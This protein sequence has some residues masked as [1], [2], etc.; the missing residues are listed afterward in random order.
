M[1]HSLGFSVLDIVAL[2]YFIIVWGGY[3]KF[4]EMNRNKQKCL[5][6][7]METYRH[8]WF[9]TL[10]K[11]EHRVI[12]TGVMSGLQNGTAFFASSALFAIGGSISLLA[13]PETLL[14]VSSN[15]PGADNS[16]PLFLIEFKIIG[17]ALIFVYAFFKLAWAYRLFNYSAIMIGAAPIRDERDTPEAKD[18][19]D[20]GAKLNII[21]SKHF[22]RGIRAF[23]FALGYLGWFIHPLLWM[24]STTFVAI[25]IYRR[26]FNSDALRALQ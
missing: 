19:T 7:L 15:I 21:A 12:D 2:C 25:V 8:I 3:S 20:K 17:L 23:F 11:R 4:A 16:I 26:I 18:I 14:K 1:I 22:N 5:N 13:T 24:A 9:K 6:Q 10:L